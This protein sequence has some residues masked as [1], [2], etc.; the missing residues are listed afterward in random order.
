MKNQLVFNGNLSYC[1][2]EYFTEGETTGY[3]D[4]KTKNTNRHW[5]SFNTNK[6]KLST[7]LFLMCS[8]NKEAWFSDEQLVETWILYQEP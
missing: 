4:N 5:G 7:G 2:S 3:K 8:L 6:N 1:A